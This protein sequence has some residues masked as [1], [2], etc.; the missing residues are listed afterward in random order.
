L[1]EAL[2]FEP[3]EEKDGEIVLQIPQTV[4]Q[5]MIARTIE[6]LISIIGPLESVL[7]PMPTVTE[8]FDRLTTE[9]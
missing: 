9:L 1:L 5:D 3:R 6:I 8:S 2:S 7:D 4:D